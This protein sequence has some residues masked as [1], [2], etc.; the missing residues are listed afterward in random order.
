MFFFRILTL[1]HFRIISLHL[2]NTTTLM[3]VVHIPD[4][5]IDFCC[6]DFLYPS[7]CPFYRKKLRSFAI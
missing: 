5:V 2:T 7:C 1:V 4:H 6:F 3:F